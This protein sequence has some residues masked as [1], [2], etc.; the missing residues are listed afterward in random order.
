MSDLQG[1]H[2]TPDTSDDVTRRARLAGRVTSQIKRETHI[3]TRAFLLDTAVCVHIGVKMMSH[4]KRNESAT[5]AFSGI[6]Y[7]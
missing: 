1:R 5:A 4:F 2:M 7:S 3:H 6:P